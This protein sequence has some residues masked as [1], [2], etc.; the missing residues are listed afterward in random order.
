[1]L[2]NT[3]LF[4][5]QNSWVLVVITVLVLEVRNSERPNSK[6]S[7]THKHSLSPEAV[8]SITEPDGMYLPL[9]EVKQWSTP[10]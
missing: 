1:M 5:S 3:N 9:S 8:S 10:S 6:A 7:W 4:N 2:M